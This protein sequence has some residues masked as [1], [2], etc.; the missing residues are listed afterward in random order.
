MIVQIKN[1]EEEQYWYRDEIG[2]TYHVYEEFES[3][4]GP[5]Y[6]LSPVHKKPHY[7]YILKKDIVHRKEKIE[8]ILNESENYQE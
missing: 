6:R 1:C 7:L 4:H 8:Y 3:V 5:A 2:K